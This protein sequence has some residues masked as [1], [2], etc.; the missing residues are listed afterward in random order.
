MLNTQQQAQVKKENKA[1]LSLRLELRKLLDPSTRQILV[2][3]LDVPRADRDKMK[4]DE[5]A[6]LDYMEASDFITEDSVAGL[7]EAVK[8][9][10]DQ[11]LTSIKNLLLKYE[12]SKLA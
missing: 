2:L 6:L 7:L 1:F 5:G 11:S 12:K 3:L 4:K 9:A 8:S 10:N